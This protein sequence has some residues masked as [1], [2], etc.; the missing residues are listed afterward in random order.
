MEKSVYKA[1]SVAVFII[2]LVA[3]LMVLRDWSNEALERADDA[4]TKADEDYWNE[5][6]DRRSGYGG[7]FIIATT[8]IM[9][10]LFMT[11]IFDA[12]EEELLA[13]ELA[14]VEKEGLPSTEDL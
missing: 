12:S 5:E 8:A 7:W 13:E 11:G 6:Y 2:V 1:I 14:S 9:I 3:G 10:V 4:Y